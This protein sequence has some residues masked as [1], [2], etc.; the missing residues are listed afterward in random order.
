VASTDSQGADNAN[1]GL[2][3]PVNDDIVTLCDDHLG[4]ERLL[5]L[6]SLLLQHLHLGQN[7]VS[8]RLELPLLRLDLLHLV[9]HLVDLIVDA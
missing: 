6:L 3:C 9:H 5:R 7:T 4:H 2:V 8:G 1:S